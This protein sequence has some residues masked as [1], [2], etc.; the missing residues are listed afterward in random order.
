MK[1]FIEYLKGKKTYIAAVIAAAF[2]VV[3]LF[4]WLGPLTAE[5]IIAIEALLGA[6][7]G[8]T[9]RAGMKKAPK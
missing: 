8:T 9:L 2:N 7:L 3:I 1:D 5:Q 4:G 6:L